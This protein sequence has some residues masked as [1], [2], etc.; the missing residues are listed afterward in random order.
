MSGGGSAGRTKTE[1]STTDP[2]LSKINQLAYEQTKAGIEKTGGLPAALE[3]NPYALPSPEE[4][5]VYRGMSQFAQTA[6]SLYDFEQR[7]LSLAEA[8]G[9][10]EARLRQAS[11]LFEQYGAPEIVNRSIQMG[12]GGR[13]GAALEAMSRGFADMTLPILADA[14]ARSQAFAQ[15]APAYGNL[16]ESRAV[17]RANLALQALSAPRVAA[18]AEYMRPLNIMTSLIGGLP[19]GGGQVQQFGKTKAYRGETDW[20]TD[21]ILPLASTAI[22]AAGA[23]AMCWIAQAI[24]GEFDPR[25]FYAR[26]WI[27]VGWRG[28]VADLAR[29]AYARFGQRLAAVRPVVWLLSPL[30]RLAARKGQEALR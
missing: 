15:M 28:R 16:M 19:Y 23:A 29:Q 14:A 18:G 21:V 12:L 27:M 8:A 9:D 20:L 17:D 3:P 4:L 24:F 2:W 11:L 22:S 7:G 5:G 25:T 26:Y 13:S 10:P 30:F 6:P 1:S